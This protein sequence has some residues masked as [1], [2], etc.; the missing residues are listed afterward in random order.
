MQAAQIIQT[1]GATPVISLPIA[2]NQQVLANDTRIVQQINTIFGNK[3][4][5]YEYGDEPDL[6][7]V[8][9]ERYATSWNGVVP[10][11]KQLAPQGRFIGPVTYHYDSDYLH[12]FLTQAQPR[13]DAVSWHEYTC[14]ASSPAA[15]CL[16]HIDDWTSHITNA[17]S[18]MTTTVKKALSIMI[19]EWNYAPNASSM[20]GKSTDPTFMTN[21]TQKAFQALLNNHIFASMQYSCTNTPAPL[22]NSDNKTLTAQGMTFQAAYQRAVSTSQSQGLAQSGTASPT[23]GDDATDAATAT[24]T[25]NSAAATATA[26]YNSAAATATAIA[27]SGGTNPTDNSTYP[28]NN[29]AAAAATATATYNSIVATV[30]AGNHGTTTTTAGANTTTTTTSSTNTT[31]TASADATATA[32]ANAAKANAAATAAANA[33]A[34]T[35]A[36]NAAATATAANAAATAAAVAA[37]NAKA[38]A[39]ANAAA[40]AAAVAAANAKATAA[41]KVTCPATIQRGS[42]SSLVKT[43]QSKLNSLYLAGNFPNSPYNFSPYS[44]ASTPLGVDGDF[45]PLT[46]AATKDYQTKHGLLVDGI[47][48]PQTWHSL[49]YC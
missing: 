35:V 34:T 15:T 41:A 21:W 40:T 26:T 16:A 7:G 3:P 18:T 23:D 6:L 14:T 1:L 42:N 33:A 44:Q 11:L 49:G 39:A 28:T 45:G 48:G 47:V 2:L 22:I 29:A 12:S 27:S 20:D 4:V 13:P 37:A 10:M 36:A 9:A 32:A 43:L 30:T 8:S 31:T 38:T 25:Y 24:A 5:Y 19:T 17:R 46:Q